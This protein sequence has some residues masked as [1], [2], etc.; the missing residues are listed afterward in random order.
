M[1]VEAWKQDY[2][3]YITVSLILAEQLIIPVN[4]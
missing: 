4:K 1:E 2:I 3:Y